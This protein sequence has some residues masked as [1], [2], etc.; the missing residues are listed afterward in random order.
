MSS[1]RVFLPHA[2]WFR[3]EREEGIRK[4]GYILSL[5]FSLPTY[6]EPGTEGTVLNVTLLPQSHHLAGCVD[7]GEWAVIYGQEVKSST[8]PWITTSCLCWKSHWFI[9]MIK[10]GRKDN[11]LKGCD[12]QMCFHQSLKE[13]PDN[14]QAKL[15]EPNT[16]ITFKHQA[17]S[18]KQCRKIGYN[19]RSSKKPFFVLIIYQ[20]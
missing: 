15:R 7:V 4:W 20:C 17:I 5:G 8:S 6:L 9:L 10:G 2:R 14:G 12:E 3:E 1:Y 11:G 13:I 18:Y 16:G 19:Q